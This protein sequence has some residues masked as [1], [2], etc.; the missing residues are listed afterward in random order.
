MIVDMVS[1]VDDLISKIDEYAKNG[2]E[3][4]ILLIK[5]DLLKIKIAEPNNAQQESNA[6]LDIIVQRSPISQRELIQCFPTWN[7]KTVRRKIDRLLL[8][9][10]IIK[11][12]QSREVVYSPNKS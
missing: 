2:A 1:N 5:R 6:M 11:F 8:S 3:M 7:P 4:A 9:G 12:R 10:S